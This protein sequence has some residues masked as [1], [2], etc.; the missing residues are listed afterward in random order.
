MFARAAMRAV[1][2]DC[3][4]VIADTEPLWDASQVELFRRRG[5]QYDRSAV[6]PQL[7]GLSLEAGAAWMIRTFQWPDSA[8]A[9]AAERRQLMRQRLRESARFM[10][11]ALECLR[12]LQSRGLPIAL[13]T[14]LDSDL[15]A[16]LDERLGLRTLFA[17]RVHL[18]EFA[19]SRTKEDGELFRQVAATYGWRA[20]ECVVVEDSP[21]GLRG[22]R[23]AGMMAIGFSTTFA[24]EELHDADVAVADFAALQE[25][26]R[27]G[28]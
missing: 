20:A 12:A 4:G 27:P 1:I 11:G 16:A 19:G 21:A 2:F 5:Q 9:L 23:A 18:L 25:L 17:D 28:E 10:D 15:F 26:L 6:K 8:A 3:E 7:V 22:A 13:A 14:A 24:A